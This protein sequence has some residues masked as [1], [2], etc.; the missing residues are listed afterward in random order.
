M[1]GRGGSAPCVVDVR[2]LLYAVCIVYRDYIALQILLVEVSIP[3]G[4]AIAC[5][6]VLEAYKSGA[7]VKIYRYVSVRFFCKEL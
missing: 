2:N 4:S 5:S 6:V 1:V 3:S 7:I